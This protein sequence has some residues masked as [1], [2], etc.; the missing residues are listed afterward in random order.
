MV[1]QIYALGRTKGGRIWGV[2]VRTTA[3]IALF[4]TVLALAA[5]AMPDTD[6]F[7][8]PDTATMFRPMSVTS[9]KDKPLPPITPQDL[10]DAEGRCADALVAVEG[11]GDQAGGAAAA[12][13]P[14]QG[15]VSL[16]QAGVPM[17]PPA[18]ALDMTECDVVKRAGVA[19]KVEIGSNRAGERVA[20]LTYLGGSRPGIYHFAGGRL[21]AM[22]RAPE[23][24]PQPKKP[25]KR[26]P[27]VGAKSKQTAAR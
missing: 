26:A 11:S 22:E 5:C 8:L 7:R 14:G 19:Q 13:Q 21:N 17:I 4:A 6:S 1:T 23:P 10:V 12:D 9:F 3:T 16:Q 15:A 20:T 18:I 27:K 25:G 2:D 24:P